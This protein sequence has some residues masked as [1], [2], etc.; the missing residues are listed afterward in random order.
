MRSIAQWTGIVIL[1]TGIS[2]LKADALPSNQFGYIFVPETTIGAC[3][4]FKSACEVKDSGH[5]GAAQMSKSCIPLEDEIYHDLIICNGLIY[6]E[7][8]RNLGVIPLTKKGYLIRRGK[9]GWS[10]AFTEYRK[11]LGYMW[12]SC[13]SDVIKLSGVRPGHAYDLK[14]RVCK[15]KE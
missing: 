10:H 13:E 4:Q 7:N 12:F 6:N 15:S 1:L 11:E 14:E 5:T 3:R 2:N 8:F 9:D